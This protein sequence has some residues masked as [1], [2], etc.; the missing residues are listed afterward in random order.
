MLGVFANSALRLGIGFDPDRTLLRGSET[1]EL[2]GSGMIHWKLEDLQR[3]TSNRWPI[4]YSNTLI[5]EVIW[6]C[7][8]NISNKFGQ[9]K[10]VTNLRSERNLPQLHGMQETKST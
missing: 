2:F 3:G 7:G 6:D 5:I 9:I 10:F 4:F 8:S 1:R